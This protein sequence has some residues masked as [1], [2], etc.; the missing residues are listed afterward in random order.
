VNIVAR[1]IEKKQRRLEEIASE[2]AKLQ[3]QLT[4]LA[5]EKAKVNTQIETAQEMEP[6]L[7]QEAAALKPSAKG[8]GAKKADRKARQAAGVSL[9]DAIRRVT[10]N[11]PAPFTTGTVRTRLTEDYPELVE[12][13]HYSSIAG[14]MRRM[15]L[16]GGYL[17]QVE[18]GG[19][20]KEATYRIAN[21]PPRP[22]HRAD[23][24]ET[25]FEGAPGR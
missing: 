25:I 10:Q 12:K 6:E 16:K 20:G 23:E 11:L 1:F 22:E 21:K 8:K 5:Q 3:E 18:K 24:Q 13:T 19:P 9:I 17:E 7:A 4:A 15:S 14:T 2:E